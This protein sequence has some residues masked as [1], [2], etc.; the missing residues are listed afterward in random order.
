MLLVMCGRIVFSRVFAIGDNREI[1]L[2]EEPRLGS[3][4]GLRIGTIFASFHI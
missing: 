4:L 2:Y 1:G 3:L